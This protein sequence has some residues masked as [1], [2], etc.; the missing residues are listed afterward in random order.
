MTR[1]LPRSLPRRVTCGLL[2]L[3]ATLAAPGPRKPATPHVAGAHPTTG[4]SQAGARVAAPIPPYYI[5]TLRARRYPGG[6]LAIGAALVRG[7]GFTTYR[8]TW[9]SGG[10]TMTGSLEVPDGRGP[11]PVVVI[12]HGYVEPAYYTV[13]L[14]SWRYGD[15]LAAHGFLVAAPD[16][17]D[18]AGSASGP[19]GMPASVAAAVATLDLISSLGSFSRADRS[20]IAL[21]GHSQGG[22]VAML[23]MVVDPH[24]RAVALFA[25]DSSDM[26]DNARRWWGDN[27]AEAGALGTPDQNPVGYAHIS[28]RR[29]FRR[30]G[31]PVLLVQG[32]AD[33][34]IPAAWT[35]AT[36]DALRRAGVRTRLVWIPGAPHIMVGSD[37]TTEV[38]TAEAWLRQALR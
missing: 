33:E 16:Y 6:P 3:L 21:I 4:T 7:G 29:Y 37:L 24:V 9:P 32:T 34:E 8:I 20:R 19:A 18:Y 25:P 15:A 2:V 17:P 11:F 23:V 12:A 13:G 14:D 27:P 38:A 31:P 5:E 36:Y 1:S 28:P 30:G 22:E 35:T 26:A 10:R